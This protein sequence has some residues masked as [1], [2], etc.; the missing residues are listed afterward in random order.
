MAFEGKTVEQ[1][2]G[3]NKSLNQMF[4]EMDIRSNTSSWRLRGYENV[5]SCKG[6]T[7][8]HSQ[9]GLEGIA[10]GF[11]ILLREERDATVPGSSKLTPC[12]Y[13][14]E[15]HGCVLSELKSP[16]CISHIDNPAELKRRLNIDGDQ[17][18]E[19]IRWVLRNILTGNA[20]DD[21]MQDAHQAV[22][23]MTSHI[24]RFPILHH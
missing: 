3:V 20:D 5:G 6:I 9:E 14:R 17:L 22:T 8:K 11:L 13:H 12:P 19:D 7:K 18:T 1:Y 10:R 15:N 23:L 21:F 4:R 16:L 2:R 24:R